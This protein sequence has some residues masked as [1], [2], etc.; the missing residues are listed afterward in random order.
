[1]E[2]YWVLEWSSQEVT[3]ISLSRYDTRV[4]YIFNVYFVVCLAYQR[5]HSQGKL[6]K[7]ICDK[8]AAKIRSIVW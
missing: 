8:Y 4:V 5:C 1:M 2:K 6:N 7:Q 3:R